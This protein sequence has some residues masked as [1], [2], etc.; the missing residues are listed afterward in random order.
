MRRYSRVL[1]ECN[2]PLPWSQRRWM[3]PS[4]PL[5]CMR[6][7]SSFTA[8]AQSRRSFLGLGVWSHTRQLASTPLKAACPACLQGSLLHCPDCGPRSHL[9][10]EVDASTGKAVNY[11]AHS[12][13]PPAAL[14]CRVHACTQSTKQETTP[15]CTKVPLFNPQEVPALQATAPTSIPPCAMLSCPVGCTPDH[16]HTAYPEAQPQH[17][18]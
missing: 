14:P 6:S 13:V 11:T 8:C 15:V 9:I 1:R 3:A 5:A 7:M 18:V 17:F 16:R 2:K 4:L 10:E 12:S